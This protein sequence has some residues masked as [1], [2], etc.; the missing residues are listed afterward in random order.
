MQLVIPSYYLFIFLSEMC[1]WF[2]KGLH[3]LYLL[4][5]KYMVCYDLSLFHFLHHKYQLL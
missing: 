5:L 4:Q 1:H 3:R 2:L